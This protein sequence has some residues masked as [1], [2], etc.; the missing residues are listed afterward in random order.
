MYNPIVHDTVLTLSL[1]NQIGVDL[2]TKNLQLCKNTKI[3]LLIW[4]TA[5]HERFRRV[6]KV[7]KL[8]YKLAYVLKLFVQLL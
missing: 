6:I 2:S 4:D 3:K 5:G 7:R 1:N 8:V